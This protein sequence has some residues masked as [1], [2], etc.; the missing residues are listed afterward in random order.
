MEL[1]Y[2]FFSST[3]LGVYLLKIGPCKQAKH[4][5]MYEY[6]MCMYV[7]MYVCI[8]NVYIYIYIYI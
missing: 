8:F 7:C 1:A 2:P 3:V 4:M 5:Y 6:T